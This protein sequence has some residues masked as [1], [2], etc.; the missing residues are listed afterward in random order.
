[1]QEDWAD[2][3][4]AECVTEKFV[5]QHSPGQ[6]LHFQIIIIHKNN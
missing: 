3:N 4:W 2:Q 1:M 6:I 5:V